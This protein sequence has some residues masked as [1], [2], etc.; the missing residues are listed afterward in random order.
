MKLHLHITSMFKPYSFTTREYEN[1]WVV[2]SKC[3]F[4]LFSA[5]SILKI[6]EDDLVK[7]L[8]FFLQTGGKKPRTDCISFQ[9]FSIF[10]FFPIFHSLKQILHWC[11]G[12]R[13][14][15]ASGIVWWFSILFWWDCASWDRRRFRVN[16]VE[17]FFKHVF[18][19]VVLLTAWFLKHQQSGLRFLRG[20]L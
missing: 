2:V 6:G 8:C 14:N 9:S 12:R 19:H 18:L 15:Y 11:Q 5:F 4:F 20:A 3:F 7:E 17:F 1:F 10:L 13:S 16:S